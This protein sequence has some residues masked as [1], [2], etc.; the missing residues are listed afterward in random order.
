MEFLDVIRSD[1]QV[2]MQENNEGKMMHSYLEVNPLDGTNLY[3]L[4][5]NSG[6]LWFG[7]LEEINAI[8]KSMLR[9]LR[10]NDF[11]DLL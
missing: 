3:Y 2:W 11:F 7:T 4:T 6:E 5:L 10:T 9:R 1:C 8:V